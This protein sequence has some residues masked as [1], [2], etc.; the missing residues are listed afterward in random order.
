MAGIAPRKTGDRHY[1]SGVGFVFGL[2]FTGWVAMLWATSH[3]DAPFVR[4]MM[5]MVS[6]WTPAQA[7][8]VW[9]MWSV[10]MGAMMLPS[11]V[12]VISVHRRIAARRADGGASA[13]A[14]FIA[15]YLLVWG[16]FSLG[17]A[18]LQWVLQLATVLS[19]MLFLTSD[20][21]G[22]AVLL[23]AGAFQFSPLK[24][25]CLKTCRTP[26]GFFL[27]NWASGNIGAFRMGLKHG[28]ICVRCC[29][30]LMAILFVLGVMNILAILLVATIVACEKLL[31]WGD[32]ISR[33]LGL[34]LIGW[35]LFQLW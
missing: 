13:N 12:P 30:A 15:A 4:L 27:T 29:W 21:L 2:A 22:A 7:V 14:C 6:S 34:I 35:G 23:M 9:I 19:P 18:A 10:M 32:R 26:A 17:A 31:P 20:K 8:M 3:M 33:P 1:R 5:P 16:A 24:S 28:A 25:A 11:A